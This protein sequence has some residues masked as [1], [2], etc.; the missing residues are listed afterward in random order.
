M[1]KQKSNNISLNEINKRTLIFGGS[2]SGKT[3]I[4]LNDL[5]KSIHAGCKVIFIDGRG[6]KVLLKEIIAYATSLGFEEEMSFTDFE[7]NDDIDFDKRIVVVSLPL[8]KLS[9]QEAT[10]KSLI[11]NEAIK[12]TNMVS[13]TS[14][15]F[16]MFGFYNPGSTK[17]V[18]FHIYK[19][20][21]RLILAAS[22]LENFNIKSLDNIDL[23]ENFD[24]LIFLKQ[25]DH[26]TAS[27]A[28]SLLNDKDTPTLTSYN[29]LGSFKTGQGI[30][31]SHLRERR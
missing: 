20:Q 21:A 17:E 25:T 29:E 31:I 15:Y 2:G 28:L 9:R 16:D 12:R 30:C 3:T 4:V 19:K 22:D 7:V 1:T 6:D 24:S 8:S 11:I 14:I 26:L 23:I 10:D 5:K 27:L 18:F 13:S